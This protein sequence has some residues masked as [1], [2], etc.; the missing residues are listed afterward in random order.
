MLFLIPRCCLCFT[1]EDDL[2]LDDELTI[3]DGTKNAALA[4][5]EDVDD[6]T[7]SCEF[8][9]LAAD[10]AAV[11]V[12]NNNTISTI[13]VLTFLLMI[14]FVACYSRQHFISYFYSF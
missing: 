2:T 12:K 13:A 7:E 10:D 9:F 3:C 14:I 4:I 11:A 8:I 1:L 6:E 5:L